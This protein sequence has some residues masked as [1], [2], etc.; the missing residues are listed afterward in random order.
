MKK[1]KFSCPC[2]FGLESVLSFEV[3]KIGGEA[4]IT[5]DLEEIREAQKLILP[6]VGAFDNGMAK[7]KEKGLIELLNRKVLIEK[8]PI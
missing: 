6:G 2:H 4:K 3:K 5:S 8:T 1:L 7:L